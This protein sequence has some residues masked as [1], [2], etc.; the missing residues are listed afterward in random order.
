M[1]MASML[2][3]ARR[4]VGAPVDEKEVS[5]CYLVPLYSAMRLLI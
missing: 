3:Q 5:V 2:M 1:Y 4:S